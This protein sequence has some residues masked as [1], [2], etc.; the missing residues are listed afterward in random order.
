[1]RVQ[2][3]H[4]LF[5]F[6]KRIETNLDCTR[7]LFDKWLE[8]RFLDARA[9]QT[10]LSTALDLRKWIDKLFELRINEFR[11]SFV[12]QE[13][14]DREQEE[15]EAGERAERARKKRKKN[16]E[17]LL[18]Y[19][20]H[21]KMAKKKILKYLQVSVMHSL[22]YVFPSELNTIYKKVDS[23]NAGEGDSVEIADYLTFNKYNYLSFHFISGF[24]VCMNI[25]FYWIRLCEESLKQR[26]EDGQDEEKKSNDDESRSDELPYQINWRCEYCSKDFSF[27][28]KDQMIHQIKCEIESKNLFFSF[29]LFF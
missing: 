6:S 24:P 15:E 29:V 11:A 13:T 3:L 21:E 17:F 19:R 22:R 12:E 2:A 1:M 18:K 28:F 9:A 8:M 7:I 4:C 27:S 5:L 20:E 14:T 10:M 26:E 23:E 25:L 16:D